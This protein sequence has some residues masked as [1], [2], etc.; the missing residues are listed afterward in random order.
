MAADFVTVHNFFVPITNQ[1]VTRSRRRSIGQD[2]VDQ[3]AEREVS[4][5]LERYQ[6]FG[7]TA[8]VLVDAARIAYGQ[9]PEFEHNIHLGDEDMIERLRKSGRFSPITVPGDKVTKE[10]E[11]KDSKL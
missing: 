10:A 5:G 6:V 8:R 9:E 1:K 2:V 3:L 4:I 7:F 11:E